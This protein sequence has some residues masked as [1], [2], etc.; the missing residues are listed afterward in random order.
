MGKENSFGATN[1]GEKKSNRRRPFYKKKG[2]GEN[3]NVVTRPKVK[4]TKFYLH[5]SA[6]RKTSESVGRIKEAI[7]V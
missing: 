2:N 1:G 4:Y 6:A 5:D 3:N 7:I